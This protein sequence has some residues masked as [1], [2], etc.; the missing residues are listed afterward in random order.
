MA[1]DFRHL[2]L[3]RDPRGVATVTFDVKDSPVNVFNDEVVRE[4]RQVVEQLERDP[5]R[6]VVFR[7]AKPSGFIAG[8]DVHQIRRLE[9]EDEVR[10]VLAAGQ[11]VVRPRRAAA[12]P[13]RRG[14]PRAV[15]GRRAGVRA[16]LPPPRR[17]RRRADEARLARGA[18][19][20]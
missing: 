6:A 15:S 11:R 12:V 17:P 16:R 2:R 10:T 7:S 3:E 13:N 18:C 5:P 9:T 4:L 14:H 19:S 20:G 8:A 1:D